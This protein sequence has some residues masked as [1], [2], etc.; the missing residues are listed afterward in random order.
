V[1]LVLQ[2]RQK[3]ASFSS[4]GETVGWTRRWDEA[5]ISPHF[6]DSEIERFT[7]TRNSIIP[8]RLLVCMDVTTREQEEKGKR[9]E[10]ARL[11]KAVDRARDVMRQAQLDLKAALDALAAAPT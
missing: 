5:A 11:Q 6:G 7:L 3:P 4:E 10:R 9:E 2:C 1:R 8:Y